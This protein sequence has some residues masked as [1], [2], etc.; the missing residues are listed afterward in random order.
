MLMLKNQLF[1]DY[2]IR[3]Y[4]LEIDAIAKVRRTS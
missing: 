1:F 2:F 4:S 3:D